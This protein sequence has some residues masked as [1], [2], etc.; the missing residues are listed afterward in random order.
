MVADLRP[1][2]VVLRVV[3][4]LHGLLLDIVHLGV[5]KDL[6]DQLLVV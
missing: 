4:Y 2:A 1:V 6:A 3:E 5:L